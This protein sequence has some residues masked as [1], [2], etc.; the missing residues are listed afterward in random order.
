MSARRAWVGDLVR[1]GGGRRAIVTDVRDSGTVWVLR[2]PVG[3]G[4][5]WET[6]DPDSLEIIAP[7][8]AGDDQ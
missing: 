3:G 7:S 2:T 4:P 5:Y 1:D 8:G 6:D